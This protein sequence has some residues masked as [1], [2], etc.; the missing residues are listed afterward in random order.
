MFQY[1]LF[2]CHLIWFKLIRF[3]FVQFISCSFM[4]EKLLSIKNGIG[5]IQYNTIQYNT[6]QYN[7]IQYNTIQYNTIQYNTIQ[8]NTIHNIFSHLLSLSK[9]LNTSANRSW[10]KYRQSI[11]APPIAACPLSISVFTVFS[12]RK[13]PSFLLFVISIFSSWAF[14]RESLGSENNDRR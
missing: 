6:I 5:V 7:T 2:S 14:S 13:L 9:N 3:N 11:N 4:C 10:C 1:N 12:G 8:Y